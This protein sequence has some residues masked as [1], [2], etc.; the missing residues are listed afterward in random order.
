MKFE[1]RVYESPLTEGKK[2]E[3]A[4]LVINST[5]MDNVM[6]KVISLPE[7]EKKTLDQYQIPEYEGYRFVGAVNGTTFSGST[8]D[9]IVISEG[10]LHYGKPDTGVFDL[11]LQN[12]KISEMFNTLHT[13]HQYEGD[14][15]CSVLGGC[16]YDFRTETDKFSEGGDLETLLEADSVYQTL[17]PF[18]HIAERGGKD[19]TAYR[20]SAIGWYKTNTRRTMVGWNERDNKLYI[21]SVS[22][23]EGMTGAE[24][25]QFLAA[26]GITKAVNLD[27]GGSPQFL[28]ENKVQSGMITPVPNGLFI[29]EKKTDET[30]LRAVTLDDTVTIMTD[31]NGTDPTRVAKG[32]EIYIH[33]LY[34]SPTE[35][36]GEYQWFIGSYQGKL[37]YVTYDPKKM[38]LTGF[39]PENRTIVCRARD[40]V[41][42][43]GGE[44]K[45]SLA[46]DET[47]RV[48]SVDKDVVY[49]EGGGTINYD[50]R[51]VLFTTGG[52]AD[53]SLSIKDLIK[54]QSKLIPLSRAAG[55]LEIREGAINGT[56]TEVVNSASIDEIY[57]EKGTDGKRWMKVHT[58]T[59]TGYMEY[60]TNKLYPVGITAK[61]VKM[62]LVSSAARIREFPI[63]GEILKTVARGET[64]VVKDFLMNE[65]SNG[66]RWMRVESEGVKGY[67]QYDP[68]VMYPYTTLGAAPENGGSDSSGEVF[69]MV[70]EGSAARIRESAVTGNVLETMTKGSAL[71]V[72]DI[73][74]EMNSD[75]FH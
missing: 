54:A 25:H 51:I 64:F 3:Y 44:G 27:G 59:K 9:T 70:L 74:F 63:F 7:G 11:V 62:K 33:T 34:Y 15:A 10:K 26:R 73:F 65:A 29:Y 57:S 36:Y 75:Y 22:Y 32:D 46:K 58:P 20:Q 48:L 18:P 19:N 55:T 50:G 61:E 41:E 31:M 17:S 71:A 39:P 40:S 68:D 47:I 16:F 53:P 5:N 13:F 14:P 49:V 56:V 38:Y 28:D 66:Y 12:G 30:P 4:E 52:S 42:I 35:D 6:L 45:K 43:K 72:E 8:P 24:T 67:A 69:H 37:G 23:N 60:D 21:I 1:K 2:I